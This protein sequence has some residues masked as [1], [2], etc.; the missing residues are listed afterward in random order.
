MIFII[1]FRL[2]TG[3]EKI[4]KKKIVDAESWIGRTSVVST[5][6]VQQHTIF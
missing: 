5:I 4:K 2:F 3:L 6:A 1:L